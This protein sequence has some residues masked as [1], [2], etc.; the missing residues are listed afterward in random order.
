[1][2]V[3]I[4]V[5]VRNGELHIAETVDK[6][7]GLPGVEI[8]VSDN[9]SNDET[10]EVLKKYHNVKLVR[11]DDPLSMIGNWNFV[12]SRATADF[13]KLV[14]HDDLLNMNSVYSQL[15]ALEKNPEAIFAFSARD[16]LF[17]TPKRKVLL[18]SKSLK[19]ERR[20][21]DALSL[22]KMVCRTGTNPIGETLCVTFRKSKM[23]TLESWQDIE[24]I[25]EL[26]TYTRALRVGPAICVPGKAGS[27]R[28]HTKSY[29]ASIE[30][31]FLLARTVRDW[32]ASQPEYLNLNS[33][34]L[35]R[36]HTQSRL[37][38]LKKQILFGIL[39]KL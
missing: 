4:L 32:V 1:M 33:T 20:I 24:M 23:N 27:F 8:V 17:E 21:E 12:T 25:Y 18:R 39:K 2:L 26:E 34:D 31:Y 3:E 29:S 15:N 28:I 9:Y 36:L 10:V 30:N 14:S 19:K 11:P 37:V 5:P 35:I 6:F 38:A 16:F 13:Y 7:Y 22:L